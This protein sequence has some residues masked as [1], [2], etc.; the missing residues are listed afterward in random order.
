M[1]SKRKSVLRHTIPLFTGI[2]LLM[3]ACTAK[4]ATSFGE[5][6]FVVGE[7]IEPGMYRASVDVTKPNPGCSWARIVHYRDLFDLGGRGN[8]QEG[9]A[10]V[11]I[12]QSDDRFETEGCTRWEQVNVNN[13]QLA[14][15]PRSFGAGIGLIG[16][17]IAPGVYTS[18]GKHGMAC[19]WE[20][21]AATDHENRSVIAMGKFTGRSSVVIQPTEVAFASY[22]CANW[23]PSGIDILKS[24]LEPFDFSEGI[25]PGIYKVNGPCH[26]WQSAAS[27]DDSLMRTTGRVMFDDVEYIFVHDAA[28]PLVISEECRKSLAKLR[29]D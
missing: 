12:Y 2:V 26:W 17:D 3:C 19:I 10:Y 7:D 1:N 20:K 28:G 9:Q 21:L 23:H 14:I 11:T 25:A 13:N 27:N 5:G 4:P 29:T 15:T 24:P 6:R 8:V 18:T 22:N 16:V